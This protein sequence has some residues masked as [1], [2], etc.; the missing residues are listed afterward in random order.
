MTDRVANGEHFACRRVIDFWCAGE[1]FDGLP[2]FIKEGMTPLVE[3]N[4]RH[5]DVGAILNYSM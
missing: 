5:W 3:N 4:L 1:V 2:E